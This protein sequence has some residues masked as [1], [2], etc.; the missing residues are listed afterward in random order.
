MHSSTLLI[1][2]DLSSNVSLDRGGIFAEDPQGSTEDE[3]GC[4]QRKLQSTRKG[5]GEKGLI[6]SENNIRASV[7]KWLSILLRSGK[8]ECL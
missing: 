2:W 1:L 7:G 4:Y 8:G 3:L 6:R 5:I